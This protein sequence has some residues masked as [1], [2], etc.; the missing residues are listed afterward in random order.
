MPGHFDE[1]SRQYL[2]ENRDYF[3]DRVKFAA[4]GREWLVSRKFAICVDIHSFRNHIVM[5][6]R[7]HI[8]TGIRLIIEA[9]ENFTT[10]LIRASKKQ[11]LDMIDILISDD[12][13]NPMHKI[14]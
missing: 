11:I 14:T 6:F 5:T 13:K 3:K 1:L 10:L 8:K 4:P 7:K 2:K 9:D 12:G